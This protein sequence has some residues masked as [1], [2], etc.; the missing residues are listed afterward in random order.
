[1]K[2]SYVKEFNKTLYK[3]EIRALLEDC[4]RIRD[5]LS[6]KSW[7]IT[8]SLATTCAADTEVDHPTLAQT[9][10]LSCY[11]SATVTFYIPQMV[12]HKENFRET[13]IHEFLH[14][15][16]SPYTDAVELAADA[17]FHP[18]LIHSEEQLVTILERMPLWDSIF[19]G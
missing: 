12:L 4:R 13:A 16:L 5:A 6:L 17:P 3:N 2:V 19:E 11:R 15:A 9:N 18:I 10:A 7:D 8:I 1:M 14:I